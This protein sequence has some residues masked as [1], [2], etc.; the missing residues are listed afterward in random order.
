MNDNEQL[1]S[2]PPK[3]M[4]RNPITRE[5][6]RH[7]VFWQI[8]IP[9][10]IAL[11]IVIALAILIPMVG[12][13]AS[14]SQWADVSLIWLIVPLMFLALITLLILM[15]LV[16]VLARLLKVLP[17]YTNSVQEFFALFRDQVAVLGD[18][19]VEPVL[20]IQGRIASWRSLK[21]NLTG[22]KDPDSY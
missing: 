2:P 11:I 20:G 17:F 3:P 9:L 10:V 16:Y 21:Q 1:P 15:V 19:L 13:Q 22:K 8:T 7:E 6:H 14:I 12:T 5:K 18:K 4:V